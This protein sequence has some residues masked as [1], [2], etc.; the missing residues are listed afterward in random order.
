MQMHIHGRRCQLWPFILGSAVVLLAGCQQREGR[1]PPEV[2]SIRDAGVPP[3]AREPSPMYLQGPLLKA[4][5]VATGDL[6]ELQEQ[7]MRDIPD[8]QLITDFHRCFARLE[9]YDVTASEEPGKY[10]IAVTPVAQRCL[11]SGQ[12]KGGGG[13]YEISTDGRFT[14]LKKEYGE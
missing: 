3:A 5:S 2:A 8:P 1:P 12:L 7:I 6:L 11:K 10:V 4:I 9:S 14:I 13:T